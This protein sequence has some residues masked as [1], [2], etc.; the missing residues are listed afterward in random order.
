MNENKLLRLGLDEVHSRAKGDSCWFSIMYYCL[1]TVHL[2]IREES[3]N[4]SK[5]MTNTLCVQRSNAQRCLPYG[6]CSNNHNDRALAILD[7]M[8]LKDDF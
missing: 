3:I 4:W 6:N 2:D 7:G 8:K 1:S 5:Q